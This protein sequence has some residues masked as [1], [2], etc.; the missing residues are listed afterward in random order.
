MMPTRMALTL[1][2][3]A[4]P[5]VAAPA[6]AQVKAHPVSVDVDV[7]VAYTGEALVVNTVQW[8]VISGKMTKMTFM[9]PAIKDPSFQNGSLYAEHED[10]DQ[11]V[12][13]S[14]ETINSTTWKFAADPKMP[15]GTSYWHFAY[16]GNLVSQKLV[17]KTKSDDGKELVFFHWNPVD[18]DA[19]LKYRNVSMTIPVALSESELVAATPDDQ[20]HYLVSD[21]AF[22]K[23]MGYKRSD[24][25]DSGDAGNAVILTEKSLNER[26][27]LDVFGKKIPG[28]DTIYLTLRVYQPDVKAQ[29]SLDLL[30]YVPRDRIAFS[31]EAFENMTDQDGG[32]VNS[33][34]IG[35]ASGAIVAA[36]FLLYARSAAKRRKEYEK[37]CEKVAQNE[38][39]LDDIWEAPQLQVG[40]YAVKGKIAKNLHPFEVGLLIGLSVEDCI[41]MIAQALA[42]QDKLVIRSLEPLTVIPNC[43]E[44]DLPDIEKNFLK[45]FNEIGV[46]DEDK[47][48]DFVECVIGHF[49]DRTWDCDIDATRRYYRELMFEN[50]D[51]SDP[52]KM[53]LRVFKDKNVSAGASDDD[54]S[55]YL[56]YASY[57]CYWMH[58]RGYYTHEYSYRHGFSDE[59]RQS[60]ADY[61]KSD[62]C[63]AGCFDQ[64]DLGNVCRSACHNACHD[65]CHDACHSA[66]HDACHS[67]CHSACV[68]GGAE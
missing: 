6:F 50:P 23:Y 60:Y 56:Y 38:S 33:L 49:K 2:L 10:S 51:E 27:K 22:Y 48:R 67:A 7:N 53:K 12:P 42:D 40:G 37:A 47:L 14:L 24:G 1:S 26:C 8:N 3:T 54:N 64:P 55:D 65:A 45:I 41:G 34:L 63:F 36:I 62:A 68:S 25:M 58:C 52:T 29:E 17:G 13:L 15:V 20:G 66:C 31:A 18:W 4:A 39:I 57:T 44:D 9:N 11:R 32:S 43:D 61:V 5:L 28:N 16:S 30:F 46:A 21:D 19:N 35:A 59:Y